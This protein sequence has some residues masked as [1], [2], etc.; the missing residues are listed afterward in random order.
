MTSLL[1][2]QA[3]NLPHAIP[4]VITQPFWD[5]CARGELLYQRCGHCDAVTFPPNEH[6]RHCLAFDQRWERSS[7]RARVYSWTTI[8]RAVTP[9]FSTPYAAAIVDLDEGYQ[10]MTNLIGV[11]PEG[12]RIGMEVHVEFHAVGDDLILPYFKPI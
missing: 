1:M 7:G 5:A 4:S 3:T 6:C 2:P 8:S 10:M 12:V 11:H 9:E